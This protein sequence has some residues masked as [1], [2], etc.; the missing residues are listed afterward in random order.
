MGFNLFYVD[1]K[2]SICI[3]I[4]ITDPP[5]RPGLASILTDPPRQPCAI[6]PGEGIK[7]CGLASTTRSHVGHDLT[8]CGLPFPWY[9]IYK[10]NFFFFL[11]QIPS[12]FCFFTTLY[13][14]VYWTQDL[15]P[16]SSIFFA[17]FFTSAGVA[18]FM[19]SKS[20]GFYSCFFV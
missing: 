15:V 7:K 11:I 20:S 19:S 2:K 17:V 13:E 12:L 18:W 16:L 14:K 10:I 8:S 3:Y 1:L 6:L 9:L 5:R 4:Y